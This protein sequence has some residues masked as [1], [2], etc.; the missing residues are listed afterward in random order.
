MNVVVIDNGGGFVRLGVAGEERP[1]VVCPN[2]SF[3]AKG[4]TRMTTGDAL[5]TRDDILSLTI[6]RPYDK[7]YLVNSEL[8]RELWTK[9][10]KAH[11]DIPPMHCGLILTQPLFNFDSCH[12][13]M[14]KV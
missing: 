1:R 3:K 2:L 11:L 12:A 9:L 14:L 5:L 6:R 10:F 4:E 7:G 13:E 8:Q